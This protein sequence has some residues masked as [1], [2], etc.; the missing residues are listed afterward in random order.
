MFYYNT[1]F[2]FTIV[3]LY[4]IFLIFWYYFDDN[5]STKS[6]RKFFNIPRRVS[7]TRRLLLEKI[8]NAISRRKTLASFLP[9]YT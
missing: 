9:S 6:E 8:K 7:T 1:I 2:V 4:I 5:L 3:I